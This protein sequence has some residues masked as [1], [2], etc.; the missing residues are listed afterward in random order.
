VALA[1]TAQRSDLV[2]H[3]LA[4]DEFAT[5]RLL[6]PDSDLSAEF[7]G[8]LLALLEKPK[9][10]TDDFLGGAVSPGTDAASEELIQGVWEPNGVITRRGH[11][12]RICI[13]GHG[14]TKPPRTGPRGL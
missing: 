12:G 14:K 4:I 11:D 8:Q 6:D 5:I 10:G 3:G 1:V 2:E 7:G 9:G 13:G